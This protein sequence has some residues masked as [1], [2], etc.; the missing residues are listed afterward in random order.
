[1]TQ[2]RTRFQFRLRT[3]LM[4]T[5]IAAVLLAAYIAWERAQ[6][7]FFHAILV[8]NT[9]P[10]PFRDDWPEPLKAILA[11]SK[12]VELDQSTIQV[13]CLCQ[14][15]D[16]EFVW[17]MDAAPGLLEHLKDRW[18]LTQIS[19]PNWPVLKGYSNISGVATPLWWSPKDDDDTTF[20]VCPQTLAGEK[21]N[22]FQVALD[23]RQNTIFVRYWFNF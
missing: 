11:A 14:G 21:G 20:F 22:R 6:R 8:G 10:V 5:T 13:H 9:G 4:I 12:G 3:L 18:K 23:K 7:Q 17:R 1:M 15:F 2:E 19:H 16:P